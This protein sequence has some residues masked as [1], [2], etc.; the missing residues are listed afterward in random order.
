MGILVPL[1]R[2]SSFRR[3]ALAQWSAPAD[4]II[5]GHMWLDVTNADALFKELGEEHGCKVTYAALVGKAASIAL[6]AMPDVNAK[7]IGRRIYR[8]KTV[9]VYYQVDI[10]HGSDLTGTVVTQTDTKPLH[11]IALELRGR[12][13]KIRKGCH[14][15]V[16]LQTRDVRQY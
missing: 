5:H 10:G 4:P 16:L 9:D 7:V 8:K 6:G 11:Q 14:K 13:K 2:Y 3:I 1:E 12:A 15:L